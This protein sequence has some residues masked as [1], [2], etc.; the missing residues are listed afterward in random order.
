MRKANKQQTMNF[1]TCKQ[2]LIGL[3]FSAIAIMVL[4]ESSANANRTRNET[5][6][7]TRDTNLSV[8]KRKHNLSF[9]LMIP[10]GGAA[11]SM[12]DSCGYYE[13]EACPAGTIAPVPGVSVQYDYS[14]FKYLSLGA[15]AQ[16]QPYW[17]YRYQ[18][19]HQAEMTRIMLFIQGMLPL[20]NSR[21]NLYLLAGCFTAFNWVWSDNAY[22]GFEVKPVNFSVA[23]GARFWTTERWG[24][25]WDVKNDFGGLGSNVLWYFSTELG[26]VV[27]F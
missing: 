27:R 19:G 11:G 14:L 17:A 6:E 4:P 26:V 15:S 9:G 16:Y 12:N 1:I 10:V 25:Y 22:Y 20:A 5:A 8:K 2:T 7:E 18:H 24:V 3:V 21:L 13:K 23:I